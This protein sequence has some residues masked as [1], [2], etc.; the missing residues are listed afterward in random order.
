MNEHGKG[1]IVFDA[2]PKWQGVLGAAVALT[3]FLAF[4]GFGLEGAGRAAAVS[5]VSVGAA[6]RISWPMRRDVWYWVCISCISL[7]HVSVIILYP[8]SNDRYNAIAL[9]PV[10]FVDIVIILAIVSVAARIFR[11]P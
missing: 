4:S 3:V 9:V 2:P 7:V 10:M 5:V 6:A 11:K 8:W 1:G